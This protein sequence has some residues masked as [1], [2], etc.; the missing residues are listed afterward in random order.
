[1]SKKT[2]SFQDIRHKFLD[3][4]RESQPTDL[5]A[6]E[7]NQNDQFDIHEPNSIIIAGCDGPSCVVIPPACKGGDGA[8]SDSS[9]GSGCC[10]GDSGCDSGG[11]SD[12]ASCE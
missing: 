5:K 3:L 4:S 11:A 7:S 1:M 12:G 10:C 9:D 6:D 8:C 2:V